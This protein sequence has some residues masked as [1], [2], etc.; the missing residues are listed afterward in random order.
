M[1]SLHILYYELILGIPLPPGAPEIT[2][3]SERFI[4]I[5]WAE[6]LDSGGA[7]IHAYQIEA[8]LNFTGEWQLWESSDGQA[9]SASIQMLNKGTEYQFRVRA[10]NKAGKS[11]PSHPS[12]AKVAQA[13]NG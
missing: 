6:P 9:T 7:P 5:A 12:K 11:E 10:V 3:W 4:N 2:D 8:R 1:R 13:K